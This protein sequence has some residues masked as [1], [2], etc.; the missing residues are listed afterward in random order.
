[1]SASIAD[2]SPSSVYHYRIV[3][4]YPGGTSAGADQ[5]F[6]TAGSPPAVSTEP[7]SAIEQ[8]SARVNGK[9]NPNGK[10]VS[11]CEFE[12]GHSKTY[13]A[14]TP[15]APA[16]GS[17]QTPVPISASLTGL[18]EGSVYHFRVRATNAN[19]TS[20]G[21]DQT[22][23]ASEAP[24][25]D[26]PEENE[27]QPTDPPRVAGED[28][29]QPT[30]T[31]QLVSP[32]ESQEESRTIPVHVAELTGAR[33]LV[34]ASNG[35]LTLE[36]RCPAGKCAGT[37]T[38]R[39]LD[40]VASGSR[41]AAKHILTLATTSFAFAGPHV[42]AIRLRLSEAARAL[43]ARVHAMS[44]RAT[45]AAHE[46][47]GTAGTTATTTVTIHAPTRRRTGKA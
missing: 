12:Y 42:I 36:L 3:V 33:V 31:P 1:M 15:C 32:I 23:T 26:E 29:Q 5:T 6:T 39:T 24:P 47:N 40:A 21:G 46:S 10:E 11:E 2:L 38:L 7:A 16:P 44:A 18:T 45:V 22:F 14:S 4:T 28:Q 43:L 34:A 13:G 30:Q 25:S 27:P 9:V 35:T 20:Y 8:T 17:G 41:H 19:G 37:I